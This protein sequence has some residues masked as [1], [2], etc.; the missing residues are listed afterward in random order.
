MNG[1]RSRR[2]RRIVGIVAIVALLALAGCNGV[3]GDD[4]RPTGSDGSTVTAADVPTD[5]PTETPARTLAPGLTSAGVTDSVELVTA[6]Q[7]FFDTHATVTRSNATVVASNGTVLYSMKRTIRR[8]Q[9]GE[10]IAYTTNDTGSIAG[11]STNVTRIDGWT[12]DEGTYLRR[13]F[14]NGSVNYS[15]SLGDS[16]VREGPLGTTALSTYL[17]DAEGNTASVVTRRVN[18]SPRYM[19]SG[20]FTKSNVTTN[21]RLTVDRQGVTHELLA[22]RSDPARGT[23]EIRN[24][25]TMEASDTTEPEA[26]SWLDT[27]RQRTRPWTSPTP[28]PAGG[29]TYLTPSE[30]TT[31]EPNVDGES[32][33]TTTDRPTEPTTG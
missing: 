7:T 30:S 25:V 23:H 31:S 9:S 11:A 20:G 27:A 3:L 29:T 14:R 12:T 6:Q 10:R 13:T 19:V 5:R 26:P 4:S 21:Y 15:E 17:S 28:T 16:L 24:H 18:G 22:V 33:N 32:S 2:W 8:G 1:P